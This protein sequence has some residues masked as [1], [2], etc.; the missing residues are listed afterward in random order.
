[1]A[2]GELE[3]A[4]SLGEPLL[5][6]VYNDAAY[7]A[8]VH[9][10]AHGSPRR[11]GALRTPDLAAYG[12]AAGG[13]GITVRSPADLD[14]WLAAPAGLCV[15]DARITPTVVANWLEEAFRAH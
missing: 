9:H 8:E 2:L 5:V 1:M 11:P 15:V 6:V 10:F 12:R 14:E 7:G 13:H 3:T 4:A